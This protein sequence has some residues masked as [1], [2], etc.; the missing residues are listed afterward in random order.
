[1]YLFEKK[2]Q[3]ILNLTGN[4]TLEN[5]LEMDSR[6]K[7]NNKINILEIIVGQNPLDFE[8][9]TNFLNGTHTMIT[10][11]KRNDWQISFYEIKKCILKDTFKK[12][13]RQIPQREKICVIYVSLEE[14]LFNKSYKLRRKATNIF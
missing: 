1:M 6:I 9:G 7:V 13:K 12:F 4:N 10:D 5:Q 8:M 2:K 14:L 3:G 11:H